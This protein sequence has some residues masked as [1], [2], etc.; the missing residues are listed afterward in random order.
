MTAPRIPHRPKDPSALLAG[1]H[2]GMVL[3]GVF[4][5]VGALAAVAV[6]GS[7]LLAV[8]LTAIVAGVVAVVAA[9]I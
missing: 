1:P 6:A 7:A 4:T 8:A 3:A 2:A 5:V 9:A